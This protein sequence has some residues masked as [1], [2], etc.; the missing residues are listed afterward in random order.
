[1]NDNVTLKN[2]SDI[3]I[4]D[5]TPANAQ[6]LSMIFRKNGY[7]TRIASNGKTALESVRDNPPDLIVLDI[8]M[9]EMDGYEVCRRL[10]VDEKVKGIPVIFLSSLNETLDKVNAFKVGGVDYMA[11]PFQIDE[12]IARIEN[13]L[14]TGNLQRELLR[15]NKYLEETLHGQSRKLAETHER[16]AVMER[17][18]DEFLNLISQELRIPIDGLFGVGGMRFNKNAP[19]L[20]DLDDIFS[21]ACK[22]MMMILDEA[23]LLSQLKDSGDKFTSQSTSLALI[24]EKAVATPDNF[25]LVEAV[26]TPEGSISAVNLSGNPALLVKAF[27]LL[28]ETAVKYSSGGSTSLHCRRKPDGAE[29]AISAKGRT[30]PDE[31]IPDFFDVFAAPKPIRAAGEFGLG[32]PVAHRILSL[33]GASVSVKNDEPAGF[34]FIVTCRTGVA[35]A[36]K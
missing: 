27:S 8:N 4:V 11:K 15:Q 9:P 24:L 16:L 14:K 6:M 1:M 30:I 22:N 18:K 5:D 26:I 33:F 10:K 2:A 19:A 29:I 17:I 31:L 7:K 36:A 28:I 3:L 25:R 35:S 32:P 12:I 13:H 21:M 34:S 20:G 23:L